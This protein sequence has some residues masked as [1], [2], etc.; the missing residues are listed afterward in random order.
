MNE[1]VY[2]QL[3]VTANV[4]QRVADRYRHNQKMMRYRNDPVLWAKDR[5]GMHLWSLQREIAESVRDNH[6]TAVKSCHASGKTQLAAILVCW[7]LDTRPSEQTRVLTTA[8]TS[9]QVVKIMWEYIRKLHRKHKLRGDVS[10]AA[11]WKSEDRD[12]IGYGRKPADRNDHGFQGVHYKWTLVILD[13]ACGIAENLWTGAEVITT[14]DDCRILAIGNPDDPA[15]TF[16]KI[17]RTNDPLWSK[18]TIPAFST[19]NFTEEKW[20]LPPGMAELLLPV[21][22]VE[23]QTRSWGK[24]SSRYRAKILAEFPTES[25]RTFFSTHI[26]DAAIDTTETLLEMRAAAAGVEGYVPPAKV[27]GVD[28]ARFGDDRSVCVLNDGGVLTIADSWEKLDTVQSAARV[29]AIAQ[30][31]GVTEVR[32]DGVGVGAGV[33]DQLIHLHPLY[34]VI[35]MIGNAVSPDLLRWRNARAYL[36]DYMREGLAT[37]TIGLPGYTGM[38]SDE[39]QFHEELEGIEYKFVNGAIL[40]ESK[41]EMKR[42]GMKSPDITDAATY[43]CAPIDVNDPSLGLAPGQ[44]QHFDPSMDDEYLIQGYIISPV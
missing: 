15:T 9:N 42:R 13:E 8:P 1:Q 40:M 37:G 35:T 29:N 14:G 2:D 18:H 32:I 44:E 30:R 7:W 34:S 36:Y 25:A 27:L 23:Q 17:F 10:E 21:S 3:T 43:A 4:T 12:V 16:G 11:E 22:W 20:E 26:L 19:P 33:V 24:D 28:I 38:G 6:R 39:K 41:E 31:L 5:L